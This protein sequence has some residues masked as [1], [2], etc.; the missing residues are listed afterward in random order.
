MAVYN[1][2]L[3]FNPVNV[4]S[5]GDMQGEILWFPWAQVVVKVCHNS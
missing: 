2:Q 5:L 1:L 4:C 3:A